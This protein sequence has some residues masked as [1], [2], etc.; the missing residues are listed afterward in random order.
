MVVRAIKLAT[1]AGLLGLAVTHAD[2]FGRVL[3][4]GQQSF[5]GAINVAPGKG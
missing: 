3:K 2:A 5:S 1:I 4:F